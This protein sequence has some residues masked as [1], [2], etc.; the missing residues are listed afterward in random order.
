[1][2]EACGE[3]KI[4]TLQRMDESAIPSVLGSTIKPKS[5]VCTIS[6]EPWS[7]GCSSNALEISSVLVH[8]QRALW[9]L[10][11]A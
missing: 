9:H 11:T 2:L 3:P 4:G 5:D 10:G 6:L 7:L 1:M 8:S